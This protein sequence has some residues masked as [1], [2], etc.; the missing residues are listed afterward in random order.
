MGVQ[1]A[2][3]GVLVGSGSLDQNLD[4]SDRWIGT[5][6]GLHW[7]DRDGIDRNLVDYPDRRNHPDCP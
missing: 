7:L 3:N 4:G 1:W 6:I 2:Y 5:Y